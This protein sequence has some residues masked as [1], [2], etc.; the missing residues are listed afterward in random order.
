MQTELLIPCVGPR[1]RVQ[2][3]HTYYIDK[4]RQV[5]DALEIAKSLAAARPRC[6]H[7]LIVLVTTSL[8]HGIWQSL[9][10]KGWFP[11]GW[12]GHGCSLA[13]LHA[14]K[15]APQPVLVWHDA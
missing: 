11:A 10:L 1:S 2:H 15:L 14:R 3:H 5:D 12:M 7:H 9:S 4:I 8:A 6:N 13:L